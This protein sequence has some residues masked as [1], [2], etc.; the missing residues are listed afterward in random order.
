M[1]QPTNSTFQTIAKRAQQK[2]LSALEMGCISI[3][4][5][6]RSY[7]VEKKEEVR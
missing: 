6:D 7:T 3:P 2:N 5:S 1:S 4:T